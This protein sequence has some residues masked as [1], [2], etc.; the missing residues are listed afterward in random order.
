MSRACSLKRLASCFSGL[1]GNEGMLTSRTAQPCITEWSQARHFAA[2]TKEDTLR[3]VKQL[4]SQT[5][6]P[7][8]DVRAALKEADYNVD[9]AFDVLRKKGA[10][11]A[12]K[13][14]TREA[15]QVCIL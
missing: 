11:A 1:L 9:S 15:S 3:L 2:V 6:A 8:G 10:A 4:R 12:V 13:K 7:I 14:A 5:G